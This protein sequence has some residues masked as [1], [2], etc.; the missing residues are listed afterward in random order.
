M[1]KKA[2]LIVIILMLSGIGFSALADKGIGKKNKTK[3]TLNINT[4]NSIRKSVSINLK[5]GLKYTGSL[6]AS[7]QFNGTSYL[8]S[9]L[10][11]YQKGNTV[12]II[13]Q[14]QVYT[15]PEIKQGYTGIKLI[16]KTH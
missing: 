9:T 12:Y 14:K 11:T 3:I 13:P 7:Q 6:M 2:K 5:T 4:G 10:L 16:I 1:L 8:N 15:V